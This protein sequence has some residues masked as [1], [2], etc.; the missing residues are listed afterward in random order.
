MKILFIGPLPEPVTGQSLACKLFYD[1][2]IAA[3]HEVR[4][5]NL[6]RRSLR[7]GIATRR[8]GPVIRLIWDVLRAKKGCNLVYFNVSQSVAG[9]IKDLLIYAILGP[10]ISSS[11]I[12]LHGGC[13]AANLLSNAHPLLKWINVWFL[14]RLAGVIVLG[15]RQVPI[16]ESMVVPE[17]IH[18]VHNFA[19]DDVFIS[20]E[21]L[22]LKLSESGPIRV[23]FLSN[24]LQGKGH[25][26]LVAAIKLLDPAV[27]TRFEFDFAGGFD[28]LHAKQSF[29]ASIAG[30]EGVHYHGTVQ[31]PMKVALLQNAH[32]FCLPTY[33]PFEGQPIS[34]L[35][36]YAAG[37][38]VLTTDHGG[39]FD[40]F[41]PELNGW[42]VEKQ[43]PESIAS[44]LCAL[45]LDPAALERFARVNT[46]R[47]RAIY[48]PVHHLEQMFNRLGLA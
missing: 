34:I 39:I 44:A 4:L 27:R 22:Q 37:C 35:E 12:H 25:Q 40:V 31:G 15:P 7:S 3:G 6:T 1:A 33:Y 48:K 43:S 30:L 41:V 17:R 42:A 16:F 47:A 32:V 13:G 24:L 14:R 23:L 9:N 20:D 8:I 18:V 38:A 5:V 19:P 46:A 21:K 11:F 26:E 2:L 28:S 36:G 29:M 45:V 10:K